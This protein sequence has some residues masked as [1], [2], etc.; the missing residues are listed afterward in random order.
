M[1]LIGLLTITYV[2]YFVLNEGIKEGKERNCLLL[3]LGQDFKPLK[4][5]SF[6]TY[7]DTA[8]QVSIHVTIN[9]TTS[10]LCEDHFSANTHI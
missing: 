7:F 8:I 1:T 10:S 2:Y 5:L 3:T 4:Y 9:N 6:L